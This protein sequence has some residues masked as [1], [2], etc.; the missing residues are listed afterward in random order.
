MVQPSYITNWL[1]LCCLFWS[2]WLLFEIIA[3]ISTLLMFLRYYLVVLFLSV[4]FTYV[5]V[6]K[7]AGEIIGQV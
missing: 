3:N 2:R 6:K 7:R 5:A 4:P 1:F